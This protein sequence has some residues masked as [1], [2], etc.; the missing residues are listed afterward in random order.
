MARGRFLLVERLRS[1]L[2]FVPMT[3]VAGGVALAA[4]MIAVDDRLG[5]PPDRLPFFVSSTVDSARA[6]LTTVATATIT[7]AGIA[8]SITLLVIQMASSQ[9]SP[10]VVH[11]IFRDS[12]NKRVIGLVMGTFIYCLV[13]LQ[14]VRSAVTDSGDEVVPHLSVLVGLVLGVV[15]ILAV[16]AFINH[17]AHAMEVSEI[18]QDVTEQTLEVVRTQWPLAEEA[19]PPLPEPHHEGGGH[20]ISFAESGWVQH[21]DQEALRSLAEPGGTVAFESGIGRYAVGGLELCTVWPPPTDPGLAERR[22]RAAVHLGRTRTLGQDPAYGIRQLADVGIRALSSGIDDPSTAQDTIFHVAAVLREMHRRVP[23]PAVT[24]DDEER[25]LVLTEAPG[26]ATMVD[27]AFEELRRSARNH[28]AVSV[29]LLEAIS[30]LCRSTDP[31]PPDD[32][33][34]ALVAQAQLVVDEARQANL[35]TADLRLV[36]SAHEERFDAPHP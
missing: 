28:P 18:L 8:F 13:V 25:V 34:D 15:A 26:Q 16:V 32:A 3:F 21:L 22:A 11:G 17:N 20:A 4:V 6:I 27:L 14:A 35:V 7:V 23:P 24:I 9:Y 1:N 36:E 31:P 5:P 12:F 2:F 33:L 10:R 30:L 29:Y 19:P